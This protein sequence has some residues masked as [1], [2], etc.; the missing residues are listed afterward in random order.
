MKV[1][2]FSF[3]RNAV[4]FG[5]PILESIE[6]VLPICNE[7]I[8]CLGNSEDG[9]DELISRIKSDKL[10]IIH[11]TWDDSLREGGKVL[12]VETDKAFDAVSPDSDWCFYIQ[13]D[14]VVHEKYHPQI[15]ESM[16]KWKDH[17]EV[18]GLLF[19]WAH[20]YATYDYLA[21]SRT[22]YRNEIRIIRNDRRI[23]SYK[24]AQ[25]FRKEGEKLNVKETNAYIYHYGW[26]KDPRSMKLKEKVFN[27]LWHDDD[28][29]KNNVREEEYFD[30]SKIDSLKLFEGSHPEVMKERIDEM[31]WNISLDLSKKKFSLNDRILY[32]FEKYTGHRLFEYKNYRII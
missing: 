20:F 9:T 15:L 28:W 14:E 6:S 4:R 8:L 19:H 13:A 16:E 5:Y 25:G 21:D 18:E 17:P 27:A 29:I 7:F 23:R 1:S 10:K 32:L 30:Y 2:G 3:V 12:A 22:W 26:V 11:S 24:D 31:N